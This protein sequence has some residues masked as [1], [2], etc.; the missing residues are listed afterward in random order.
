[1]INGSLVPHFKS[2]LVSAMK[3]QPFSIA[4]DRSNDSGLEPMMVRL[5]DVNHG[6]TVTRFLDMCLK[7]SCICYFADIV[8][9]VILYTAGIEYAT[10]ESIFQKMNEVLQTNE[11]PWINCVGVSVDNTSVNL[12]K[13]NYGT[14]G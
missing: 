2:A 11:V 13:R 14:E 12:G 5:Y 1:M 3:S 9:V 6:K 7:V 4:V 10:A 8:T